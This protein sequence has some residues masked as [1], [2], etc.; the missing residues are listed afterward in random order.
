MTVELRPMGVKCNIQC[1]YCYQ[2]PQRDARNLPRTYDIAKMKAAVEK[3]GGPLCLFGGEPLLVPVPDL[4]ALLSWGLEKY[5]HNGVQTNG[6]L[7]NDAH[8]RLFKTYNVSVGVSVDGPGECNDARWMG[9]L[10]R[11]REATA[12]SH[13]S[14]ERLCQEGIAPSLIVTL[15]R[16]NAARER[17]PMMRDWFKYLEQIG[18]Y[19]AR[20]HV[21]EIEDPHI[22]EKY[23]LSV[24]ENVE[25]LLSLSRLEQHELKTLKFDLFQ[26]MRNLLMGRDNESSCVW[27]ACDPYTTRAVRGIEGSGQSSNCGR[28]NKDGIDFIKGSIEGFERYLALY[29]TPQEHGGCKDC[30]FFLMCKGQCPGTA[31]DGDWRNRTEYCEVWKRLY[32][33]FESLMIREG[34][35]PIS[36]RPDRKSLE[37]SFV[38]SWESG[39]TTTIANVL[40]HVVPIG[41]RFQKT[42]EQGSERQSL[43]SYHH[44]ARVA[45]PFPDFVRIAWVNDRAKDVWEP[46]LLRIQ[47]AW[48]AIEWLSVLHK[49]RRCAVTMADPRAFVT[50]GAEWASHGL[51]ALPISIE[52]Q[53]QYPYTSTAAPVEPRNLYI[54]RIVVGTPQDVTAFKRAFDARDDERVGDLLGYPAC[55]RRFFRKLWVERGVTDTTW[56]TALQNAVRRDGDSF[57]EVRGPNQAN[58]L[59]RWLGIRAIPHLPCRFD[60]ETS[61]ELAERLMDV[62]RRAGYAEEVDWMMDILSWPVEWTALHG[63]AE[64]K[65]PVLK[66]STRTDVTMRKCVVQRQGDTYPPE[67][68]QG[69]NF[70]YRRPRALGLQDSKTCELGSQHPFVFEAGPPRWLAS[71]NG[72]DSLIAMDNAHR[73]II[74][75]ASFALRN[76]AGNIVDLGCGNGALLQEILRVNDKVTLFGVDIEPNRI[77]HARQLLPKFAENFQCDDIFDGASIWSGKRRYSLAILALRRLLEADPQQVI[78]LKTRL[79]CQCEKVLLYIYGAG[80]LRKFGSL[81]EVSNLYGFSLISH[82]ENGT[83]GLAVIKRRS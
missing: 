45:L 71:D 69:L 68:A 42:G 63:I 39:R 40:A 80:W 77:G 81:E 30:R 5:G 79:A 52:G 65:T 32:E 73:P 53:M 60:C 35:K 14:I 48:S 26:E 8:I 44:T 34:E 75:L 25:A 36:V 11:T 72:F 27:N 64:I 59:W 58:T 47:K 4:E 3:E 82:R 20:L 38:K 74:D 10:E 54:F 41:N 66:I 76:H 83:V 17:L 33:H 61:A 21:L 16:C 46:R 28:T 7:I 56:A 31:I 50:R 67:G 18:I 57:V 22:R 24:E 1:Q 2:N 13:A 37:A 6:T 29:S 49:I 19:S 51:N 23:G 78:R 70:P 12:K 9:T 62:G 55:C 15:H 43:D